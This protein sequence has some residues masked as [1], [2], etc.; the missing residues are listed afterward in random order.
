MFSP[1]SPLVHAS[2]V[3][4]AVVSG[5]A[6]PAE[7]KKT[8]AAPPVTKKEADTSVTDKPKVTAVPSVTDLPDA[9]SSTGS[10]ITSDVESPIDLLSSMKMFSAGI[11]CGLAFSTLLFVISLVINFFFDLIKKF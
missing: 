5:S 2:V 9:Q 11:G 7:N 3:S 1:S 10:A 6:V 8:T 4:G